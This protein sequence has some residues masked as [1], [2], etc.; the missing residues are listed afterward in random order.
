[1][2][3]YTVDFFL[4]PNSFFYYTKNMQKHTRMN[5][6]EACMKSYVM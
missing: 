5:A 2:T 4:D 1:M 3:K 6:L